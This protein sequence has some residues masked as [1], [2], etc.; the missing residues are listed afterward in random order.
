MRALVLGGGGQVGRA[1]VA[2]A[3]SD[4]EATGLSRGECDIADAEAVAAALRRHAPDIVFNAA[5]LTAVD[6][7]EA[8]PDEAM[9]INGAA[10]GHIARACKAAGP[11]LVHISTDFVFDGRKGAPY[12]PDDPARPTS[13]YGRSK[14]AGEEAVQAALP[15]AAIVRT[16][17]VYA[18]EGG[19]FVN[20]MLRAM[21]ERD[22][23]RVVAD[24][25]GTPTHAASL[26]RALWKL[27][28]AGA[29]GIHHYTDAGIAGW[30]DFAVAIEEEGRALGLHDGCAVRPIA[31]ADYPTAARRPACSLLDKSATWA[32]TGIP[33]HWRVELRRMLAERK[34]KP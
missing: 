18:A 27:A 30:Y 15:G 5:A 17:W 1:L 3:G 21:A 6:A 20:T 31:T 16:A 10:P 34:G 28:R 23:V 29:T 19:N 12:L 9:R 13:V 4:D 32:I 11:R 33:D 25:I 14:A 26:A 7:Q 24:Q 22:E 8:T 2:A